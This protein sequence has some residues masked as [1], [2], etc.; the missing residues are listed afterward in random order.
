MR[1]SLRRFPLKTRMVLILGLIAL[2]QTG[3]LGLFAL[4]Y[5]TTSLEEEIGE[6][7]LHVAKTIASIPQVIDAVT[8]R[9]ISRLQPLSLTLAERTEARF[10]V[11]GD[12]DG[13]RLAHPVA[14]RLGR[15]MA[16]D[17]DDE[18]TPTLAYG[19]AQVTR[20][21]GS[22]GLSM[23]ARAPIYDNSGEQIVGLVSVGYLLDR[24]DTYISR[25]RLTMTLV[26]LA[27][28]AFSI[29][30]AV[31]FAGHFKKAIFGLEPEEIGRLFQ[32]RNATLQSI[33]EGIIAINTRG[34]ITTLNEA[35]RSILELPSDADLLGQPVTE[36]LPDSRMPEVLSS[37]Q[38]QFDQEVRLGEQALIVN[39]VP[40]HHSGQVVGV[41]SSFRRKDELHQLGQKLSRIQQYADSLRSQAHEYSNKLHTIA[42][43]IQIGAN[44]EALALIGQE[45]RD[46]QALIHLLVEAVPDPVL[47]GCL[48]GKY[49][50]ARELGLVLE[51][52]PDSQMSDLPEWIPREQLV[53]IL[54]NLLDNAFEAT[55]NQ[56]GH[57]KAVRMSMTDLGDDLIFEIED[58]GPG[59][60][61]DQHQLIFNKGVTSKQAEGHGLGL[62]LVHSLLQQ[63]NGTI[64][65][66][67]GTPDGSRFTVYI[68]KQPHSTNLHGA[69]DE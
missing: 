60:P 8:E 69:A 23:R 26:I 10:V 28:L 21:E 6:R 38:P 61:D 63:L 68:P 7:A 54:G 19:L 67:P 56:G 1:L 40:L 53:S 11:I 47:A 12:R 36:V 39:R 31:W 25:Y 51:I 45:T 55:L 59:I 58:R 41:V 49:N 43:L 22:L 20:A 50:R 66:E 57:G 5:L 29:L 37:D 42:G 14:K 4:H 62:H 48:L 64:T 46:H 52:D 9:D 2:L 3:A 13:L 17:D 44:D 24:V 18:L 35:A 65:I 34:E 27:A 16:E 15:S 33:R 32:E 30:T